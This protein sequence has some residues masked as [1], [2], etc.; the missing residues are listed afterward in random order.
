MSLTT[1]SCSSKNFKKS[2]YP[3]VVRSKP[4]ANAAQTVASVRNVIGVIYPVLIC[5]LGFNHKLRH[6]Y[7]CDYT[8][9]ESNA[10][11]KREI[12]KTASHMNAKIPC[13]FRS[14][15]TWRVYYFHCTC[16]NTEMISFLFAK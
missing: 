12:I 3:S 11:S 1:S 5:I 2:K 10:K 6:E 14:S 15:D 13:Y 4:A 16:Q 9:S 7:Y 8:V